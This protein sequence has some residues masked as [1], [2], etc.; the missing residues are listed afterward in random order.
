VRDQ[1]ACREPQCHDDVDLRI[2][3]EPIERSV[4]RRHVP[5]AVQPILGRYGQRKTVAIDFS[6]RVLE[7]VRADVFSRCG[8]ID[9]HTDAYLARRNRSSNRE[10]D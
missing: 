6:G 2:G 9:K 3:F 5:I 10:Q 7:S 4:Q 8:S 1:V